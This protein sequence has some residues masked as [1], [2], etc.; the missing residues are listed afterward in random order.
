[1]NADPWLQ[2]WLPLVAERGSG[3]P[4][5]ELGCGNGEDTA[6]LIEIG[7]DVIALDVCE[8]AIASARIRSPAARF[9]CRDLREPFPLASDSTGVILASLSLHYFPWQETEALLRRIHDTLRPAGLL[10]CRL[11]STNDHHYGASGHPQIEENYY[12]VD[13]EPKRFFDQT[14]VER[15]FRLG[16][17]ALGREEKCTDKY[18]K[19]K[20][21]WEI[22]LEKIPVDSSSTFA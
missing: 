8:H 11:N 3:H 2:R 13:G 20:S 9:F 14:A 22:V 19:P 18:K 15:L 21:L 1:M 5:L 17:N 10:L 12:S 7:M 6:T 16:W 4:V